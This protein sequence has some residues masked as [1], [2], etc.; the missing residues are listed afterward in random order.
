MLSFSYK[1]LFFEQQRRDPSRLYEISWNEFRI[2]YPEFMTSLQAS[3]G[4]Q[5]MRGFRTQSN[6]DSFAFMRNLNRTGIL[7]LLNS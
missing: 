4:S 1:V 7:L 6:Q 2:H 5:M 3:R